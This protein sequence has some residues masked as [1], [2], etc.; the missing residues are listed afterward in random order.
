MQRHVCNVMSEALFDE[1]RGKKTAKE[2]RDVLE[3]SK[4]TIIK[5]KKL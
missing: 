5:K 2:I 1:Y 3:M 4:D